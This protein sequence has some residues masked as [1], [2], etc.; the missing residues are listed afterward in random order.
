MALNT[1]VSAKKKKEYQLITDIKADE[2]IDRDL[3]QEYIGMANIFLSDLK[4]N[5]NKTSIEM[6]DVEPLGIDTWRAFLSYPVV[7]RYIQSFKEE[8]INTIAD[9]GMMTGDNKA[10]GIKK[11][12]NDMNT[13]IN[14]SNIVLIRLPEKI[15]FS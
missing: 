14:N 15:D 6:D 5:L 4:K 1:G 8:Q 3:K 10:V 12:M 7:R 2:K 13:T 11:A 9:S